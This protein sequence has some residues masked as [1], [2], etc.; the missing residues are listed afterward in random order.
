MKSV[1]YF[2][3]DIYNTRYFLLKQEMNFLISSFFPEY[4]PHNAISHSLVCTVLYNLN[5]WCYLEFAHIEKG[6]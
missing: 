4:P 1:N 2:G 6:T 3:I 5:A